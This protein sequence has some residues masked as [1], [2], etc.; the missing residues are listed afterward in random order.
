VTD[1]FPVNSKFR[2]EGVF[3][4][5]EKADDR[6][7]ATLIRGGPF[8]ELETA[9]Q[10]VGPENM[11]A[12]DKPSSALLHG[13]TTEGICT[14]I[15]I[16]HVTRPG[17]FGPDGTGVVFDRFRIDLCAIRIHLSDERSLPFNTVVATYPLREWIPSKIG[18]AKLTD[19]GR[20]LTFK[21][22]MQSLTLRSCR[23][24]CG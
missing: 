4:N 16:H 10:I 7:A 12:W 23:L 24:R 9:A 13:L 8:I 3:W 14:L 20:T 11:F 18:E 1:K 6:F 19:D 21:S 15:G 17:Y 2:I 5:P 22:T